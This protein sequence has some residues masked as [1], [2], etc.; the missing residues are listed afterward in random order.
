M[1]RSALVDNFSKNATAA[2]LQK[3]SATSACP[4]PAGLAGH[5]ATYSCT[6]PSWCFAWSGAAQLHFH[7]K[8][9]L[10]LSLAFYSVLGSLLPPPHPASQSNKSKGH[11]VLLI[12]LT[13]IPFMGKR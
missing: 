10:D 9:H 12:P 5:A 1:K 6:S 8:P 13:D 3:A 11:L 7:S 2:L 4:S